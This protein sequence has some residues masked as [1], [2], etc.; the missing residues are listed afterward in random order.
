M[1]MTMTT[2]DPHR[3]TRRLAA[4]VVLAEAAVLLGTTACEPASTDDPSAPGTVAVTNAVIIDGL[5][6]EPV[7]DGVCGRRGRPD[8]GRGGPLR[9]WPCPTEPP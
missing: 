7:A 1:N 5:G 2:G 6:G 8:R 9:K 4:T 3:P